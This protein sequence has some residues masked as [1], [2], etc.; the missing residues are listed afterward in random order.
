MAS[1]T[2]AARA[3]DPAFVP[4]PSQASQSAQ[5]SSTLNSLSTYTGRAVQSINLPGVPDRDHLLQ[6]LPQKIGEPLDRDKVRES[7]RALFATGRFSDIQAEVSPSADGVELTFTTS[8]NFFVGGV[9]VEGAPSHPNHNQIV[10]ASKFQLGELYSLDKL[11]RALQ[12]IRQL[13]QENGHYRARVVRRAL[14]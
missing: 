12:N 1:F 8:L 6:M 3:G 4:A 5:S 10:N 7:I 2:P 14:H 11:N 13:M 9:D